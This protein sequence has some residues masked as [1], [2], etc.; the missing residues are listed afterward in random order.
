MSDRDGVH[1]RKGRK[2]FVLSYTN[3]NGKRRLK[4]VHC[5]TVTEARNIRAALLARVEKQRILGV[6]D[7]EDTGF[8]Q[9]AERYLKYQKPRVSEDSYERLR[10]II[11]THLKPKFKG[12]IGA[13]TRSKI[14]DFVTDRLNVASAGTVQKEFNCVKHILRLAHE[15]WNLI[16]ENPAKTLTLKSLRIK[17][18]PGRVRYLHPDELLTLLE[19]CPEWLRPIVMLGVATGLRRGSILQLRWPQYDER[20]RMLIIEKT[21]NGERVIVHLNEIGLLGLLMAAAHFGRGQIGKVFLDVTEDMVSMAFRRAREK[22]GIEDFKFHDLRHTNA[23]WLRMT[24]ADI[25]TI[26]IMLGHKDIRMSMRYSH[27]SDDFLA[28]SAKQLDGVFSSL[29]QLNPGPVIDG[30]FEVTDPEGKLHT[31][32]RLHPLPDAAANTNRCPIATE[33]EI[34]DEENG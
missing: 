8:A 33:A 11:E 29:L 13:I 19:A 24:G 23:S 25:H 31:V 4:T 20:R 26:A 18:P 14:S 16:P 21:K 17:L 1:T 28:G 5:K 2:G 22:A 30:E 10:G 32:K 7:A 9:V 3:A 6:A 27:L 15:E 34:A 12:K